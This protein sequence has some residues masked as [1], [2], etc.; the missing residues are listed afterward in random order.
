[1]NYECL[2]V[3]DEEVLADN[4]CRYLNLSGIKTYAVYTVSEYY[5]FMENNDAD[6]VLLDIN[7]TDGNG[8]SLCQDIR[9]HS[10]R[11]IIFVSGQTEEEFIILGLNIGADDFI[12]KPYSLQL[13][14]AKVKATLRRVSKKEDGNIISAGNCQIDLDKEKVFKNGHEVCLR[15]M[16]RKLLL[17][18]VKNAN[19]L[20]SKDEIFKNVWNEAY[21]T[22]GTLNVHIRKIRQKIEDNPSEPMYIIT[23]YG[24]GYLFKIEG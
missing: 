22:D 21:V 19:K 12:C 10:Q 7:L 2:I 16:E 11:P 18:L 1:M 17:Y 15:G 3:E 8:Y 20:I 6:V 14:L 5:A 4:A 13:L 9:E 24:R 23:E